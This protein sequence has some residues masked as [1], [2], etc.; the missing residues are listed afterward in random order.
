MHP[1]RSPQYKQIRP[2]WLMPFSVVTARDKLVPV[3]ACDGGRVT[4]ATGGLT[5]HTLLALSTQVTHSL[6]P[7]PQRDLVLV[8]TPTFQIILSSCYLL[9][10]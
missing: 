7:S 2:Q 10:L 4:V 9:K 8:A 6:L 1:S 3:A 5:L